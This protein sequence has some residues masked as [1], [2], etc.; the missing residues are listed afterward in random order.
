MF[1]ALVLFVALLLARHFVTK[2]RH[3]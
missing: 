3:A 2:V 1:T